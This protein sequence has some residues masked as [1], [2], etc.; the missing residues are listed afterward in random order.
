METKVCQSC[1]QLFNYKYGTELCNNCKESICTGNLT[2]EQIG[3][4]NKLLSEEK[5]EE[6]LYEKVKQYILLH[7]NQTVIDVSKETEVGT[8]FL[9][10]W[11]QEGRLIAVK[12]NKINL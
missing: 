7:P 9:L 10:K 6:Q 8:K 11:V 5:E 2:S 1:K 3:I 4:V 12:N